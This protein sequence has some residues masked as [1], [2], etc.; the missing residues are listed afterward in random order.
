MHV[1]SDNMHGFFSTLLQLCKGLYCNWSESLLPSC[2]LQTNK[3]TVVQTRKRRRSRQII[4]RAVVRL[5]RFPNLMI[6]VLTQYL[7]RLCLVG[8]KSDWLVHVLDVGFFWL[9][10]STV[11]IAAA[12][13]I[14]NDYYDIK[15]DTINKPRRMVVGRIMSRRQ[16][17]FL[18]S[19]LNFVGIGLGTLVALRIGLVNFLAAF[20]LWLYSNQ[21]KRLPFIGNFIVALLTAATLWVV[22]LYDTRN[23]V[24]VYTY[25]AFAFFITLIREVIKD[26]EDVRGDATF[27]CRTLPIVWGIR[28]TKAL[29]YVLIVFFLITLFAFTYF[30]PDRLVW[31][32][33][34]FILVPMSWFGWR[35]HQA[36]TRADFGYLSL[37]C[38]VISVVGVMSMIFV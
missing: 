30:L 4:F 12:G 11:C 10:F 9:C 7:V 6:V 18:H 2:S 37:V 23:E 26:M 36:D 29:L 32:F 34:L 8:P 28:R 3:T 35:L 24:L 14:I 38:K 1:V 5:V 15:I 19:I 13:Y 27:G 31:Y 33:S 21:L 22:V 16:A 25:S 17:I 20:L